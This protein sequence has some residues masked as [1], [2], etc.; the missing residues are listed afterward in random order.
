MGNYVAELTFKKMNNVQ[1]K[2]DADTVSL[3]KISD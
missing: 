2:V 1:D 3:N